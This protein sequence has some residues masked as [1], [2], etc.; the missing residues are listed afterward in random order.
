MDHS[1]I[2]ELGNNLDQ[3]EQLQLIRGTQMNAGR[4]IARYLSYMHHRMLSNIGRSRFDQGM[5]NSLHGLMRRAGR[6][7]T[8]EDVR[9]LI[10]DIRQ[11]QLGLTSLTRTW[12]VESRLHDLEEQ[13]KARTS[14]AAVSDAVSGAE[15]VTLGSLGSKRVLFAIMPFAQEFVDVWIGGIKRAA[16]GSG[17]TALRIDML[18]QSSEITD[19]IVQGIRLSEVV[20]V[21]VTGNNPNVMFEF[22]YAL[23]LNKRP[24]V[25]SQSTEFLSFDIKNLRTLI[26]RN[27]WQGIEN[28][29]KDLQPFIKGAL[30][31]HRKRPKHK[32]K[33]E[34][35]SRK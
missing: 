2:A 10:R 19:D 3:I 32:A 17:L 11:Y 16:G 5:H 29:H 7:R 27:T 28:L 31:K 12:D 9:D 18:T 34:T 21:D 6:T 35:P 8:S 14:E 22:G 25:I 24:V 23:A 1:F 30:A 20:V 26:Y 33:S 15:A 4:E 13:V